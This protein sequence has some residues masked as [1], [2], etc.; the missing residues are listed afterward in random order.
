MLRAVGLE[1]VEA[2][3][4]VEALEVVWS[5]FP[6]DLLLAEIPSHNVAAS[7]AVL[8]QA[9]THRPDIKIIAATAKVGDWP[10]RENI[11]AICDK[12]Y[13]AAQLVKQIKGLLSGDS[14]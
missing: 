11:D 6:I 9:R 8:G 7:M 1:V 5:S 2:A 3:T 14:E 10:S 12:P 4:A 13:D